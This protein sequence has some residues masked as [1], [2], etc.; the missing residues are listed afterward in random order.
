MSY[1]PDAHFLPLSEVINTDCP[2]DR[3]L[4]KEFH[5]GASGSSWDV[6]AY[7]CAKVEDSSISFSA[8]LA[9]RMESARG[10]AAPWL[11]VSRG[12]CAPP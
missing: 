8:V 3:G 12:G 2:V 4:V 11:A 6:L 5:S 9:T 7:V 10:C 1:Q